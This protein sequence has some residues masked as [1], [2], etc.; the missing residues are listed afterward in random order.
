MRPET[1]RQTEL[2]AFEAKDTNSAH[3]ATE[4]VEMSR[5]EYTLATLGYRQVFVRSFGLFENVCE[6]RRAGWQSF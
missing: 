2:Q 6:T 1:L 5:D 4:T 3:V